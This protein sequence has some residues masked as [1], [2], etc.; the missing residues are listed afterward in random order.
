MKNTFKRSLCSIISL[1]MILSMIPLASVAVSAESAYEVYVSANGSDSAA[2]TQEAPLATVAAAFTKCKNK[3]TATVYIVGEV[4]WDGSGDLP[5]GVTELTI[6]GSGNDARLVLGGHVIK[7]YG[8]ISKLTFS[9]MTI[10]LGTIQRFISYSPGKGAT[11]NVVYENVKFAAG[12]GGTVRLYAVHHGGTSLADREMVVNIKNTEYINELGIAG[13]GSNTGNVTFNVIGGRVSYLHTANTGGS[14]TYT[15][16][17]T[18]NL[19][20]GKIDYLNV[21][22]NGANTSVVGNTYININGG[23]PARV[24]A[25]KTVDGDVIYTVNNFDS[26][27]YFTG[28][29]VTSGHNRVLLLNNG[30]TLSA[31]NIDYNISSAEGV[32]SN[33]VLN[34]NGEFANKI[35]VKSNDPSCDKAIIYDVN[36]DVVDYTTE[37]N[38]DG[39]F[40]LDVTQTGTYTVECEK[41]SEVQIRGYQKGKDGTSVR[42]VAGIDTLDC[43][44]VGFEISANGKK[45]GD[46]DT[47]I[48]GTVY[49]SILADDEIV[50]ADSLASE[51]LFCAKINGI[52]V[53]TDEVEFT[54]KAF[55]LVNG[56]RVYSS[57]KTVTVEF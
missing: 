26:N 18:V 47:D 15:G 9:N 37:K 27:T 12:T 14:G 4:T 30:K 31:T 35:T 50:T 57:I 19:E 55:K 48:T 21:G 56:E 36:N 23:T 43:N 32:Y 53:G 22:G 54:V 46:K 24:L 45:W 44:G 40:T 42:F 49:K 38:A 3:V 7:Y 6:T 52:P 39:S 2:G 28:A 20:S 25:G 13:T 41:S 10:Y 34:E 51:Y 29:N 1:I 33:A 8:A 17:V 16:N 5:S 11:A